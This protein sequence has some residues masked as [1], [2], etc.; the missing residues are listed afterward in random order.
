[1]QRRLKAIFASTAACVLLVGA[2]PAGATLIELKFEGFLEHYGPPWYGGDDSVDLTI[3]YDPSRAQADAD[4]DPDIGIYQGDFAV[5]A[6]LVVNG[7]T[8]FFCGTVDGFGSRGECLPA[9]GLSLII[10]NSVDGFAEELV[11]FG[12]SVDPCPFGSVP[13]CQSRLRDSVSGAELALVN[14][15]WYMNDFL[16]SDSIFQL[17]GPPEGRFDPRWDSM[18][19]NA[20]MLYDEFGTRTDIWEGHPWGLT[21]AR[22]VPEPGTLALFGIGLLGMGLARRRKESS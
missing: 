2:Q 11:S 17:P 7:V 6:A 4:P 19:F 9:P 5:G 1:M 22:Y 3:V 14:L 16:D 10:D 20:I 21:S 15:F 13:T 12:V 18:G 8:Q